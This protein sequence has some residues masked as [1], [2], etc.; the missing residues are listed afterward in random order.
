[1]DI[2]FVLFFF[3]LYVSSALYASKDLF[4]QI[5]KRKESKIA[6]LDVFFKHK[7]R[8]YFVQ[9]CNEYFNIYEE[10][11][12]YLNIEKN[13]EKLYPIFKLELE[14]KFKRTTIILYI[15]L[16]LFT[17]IVMISVFFDQNKIRLFI[18]N[19]F[20]VLK[21]KKIKEVGKVYNVELNSDF[22]IIYKYKKRGYHREMGKPAF[23]DLLN[24]KELYYAN[25]ERYSKQNIGKMV[26][27]DKLYN[28]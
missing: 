3:I 11:Y 12:N 25:N 9:E 13:P 28:F 6:E 27:Q 22:Q 10:Y 15:L 7:T 17:P 5:K 2:I 21:R 23:I 26:M 20:E 4:I 24:I 1:M 19:R 18:I 14:K 16:I 8:S